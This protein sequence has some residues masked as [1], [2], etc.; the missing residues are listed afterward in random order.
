MTDQNAEISEL[1]DNH[2][3]LTISGNESPFLQRRTDRPVPF[4]IDLNLS[5]NGTK[6]AADKGDVRPGTAATLLGTIVQVRISPRKNRDRRRVDVTVRARHLLLS[7]RSYLMAS[8]ISEADSG[9]LKKATQAIAPWLVSD[10][11]Q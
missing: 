3:R 1:R 6:G 11:A 5:E 8:E 9:V 10:R 4:V 2:L 7:L